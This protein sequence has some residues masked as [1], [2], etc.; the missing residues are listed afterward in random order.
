MKAQH[1]AVAAFLAA[2]GYNVSAGAADLDAVYD[3]P[4]G[5]AHS[6]IVFAGIDGRENSYDLYAGLYHA[7]NGDIDADGFL[8]RLFGLYGEYDYDSDTVGIGNVDGDVGYV[9][10]MVGYQMTQDGFVF[11]GFLG[12]EYE[13]HDLSPSD[14]SNSNE[15]GDVGVKLLGEIETATGAPYYANLFGSYGSAKDSYFVRARVGQ[16]FGGFVVGPE[17]Q[18]NGNDEYDEQRIGAFVT[19]EN[20]GQVQISASAGYSDTDN[21]WGGGSLYGT[22]EVSTSF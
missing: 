22:L 7:L 18:L 16:D 17:G 19:L 15:G 9:D 20:L 14:P 2:A 8:V 5:G 3:G 4:V 11:R 12:V 13:D 6:T 10:A 1:V 21:S